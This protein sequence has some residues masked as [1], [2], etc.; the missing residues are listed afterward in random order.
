MNDF[1]V[2]VSTARAPLTISS[3][4]LGIEVR[5]VNAPSRLHYQL[6]L[7]AAALKHE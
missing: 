2:R 1:A 6:K 4:S 3:I 7:I 5:D